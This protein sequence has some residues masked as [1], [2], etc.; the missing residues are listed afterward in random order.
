MKTF[1]FA[2]YLLLANASTFADVKPLPESQW[3][4]TTATAIPYILA[5]MTPTTRSIVKDTS[6]DS[7]FLL[8]GEW[9]A[10]VAQ[11][12]GLAK[13][14]KALV[15]DACGRPCSIEQATLALMQAA[16]LSLQR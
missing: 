2:A 8:M 10:D 4:S 7:L 16:R 13:G 6:E 15:E 3:P 9:G 14:N 11:L 5:E 12:L 1:G